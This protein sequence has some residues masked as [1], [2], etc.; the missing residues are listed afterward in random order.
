MY[1]LLLVLSVHDAPGQADP[2]I[3]VCVAGISLM[4][5]LTAAITRGGSRIETSDDRLF[6][7]IAIGGLLLAIFGIG[8]SYVQQRLG[9]HYQIED[10]PFWVIGSLIG[11]MIVSGM[12]GHR[13]LVQDCWV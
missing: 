1:L 10:R 8:N 4:M 13:M 9:L 11:F 2:S 5:V 6:R 7:R 3:Y 12:M